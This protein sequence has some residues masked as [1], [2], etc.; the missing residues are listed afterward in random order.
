MSFETTNYLLALGTLGL[1]ASTLVLL[2]VYVLRKRIPDLEDIAMPIS[3]WSMLIALLVAFGASAMTLIHS[4]Y[5]GLPPCDLCWWQRIFLYP[6][7]VIFALALYKRERSIAD[8]SLVLSALGLGVALYHHALQM[9]PSGTLPCPAQG[10]SCSQI[11]FLEFG[12]IT[13]PMMGATLFA[14]LIVLML[15]S[16]PR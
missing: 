9:F 10:V 8:Y 4:H 6:Q 15:F 16:R 1:Q 2:A 14:F 3:R 13:Y 5:F 11:L 7:V 12:F